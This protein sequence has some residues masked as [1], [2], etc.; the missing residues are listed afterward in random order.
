MRP[1]RPGAAGGARL[2]L[3]RSH[4]GAFVAVLLISNRGL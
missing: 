1:V 3:F 2:S 4:H